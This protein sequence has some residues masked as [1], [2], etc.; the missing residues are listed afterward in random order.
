MALRVVLD[1]HHETGTW[2][3]TEKASLPWLVDEY[4]HIR[5]RRD[6]VDLHVWEGEREN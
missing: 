1:L 5:L 2:W 6:V 4:R 3:T